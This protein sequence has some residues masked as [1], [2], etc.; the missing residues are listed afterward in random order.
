MT[1]RLVL[2]SKAMNTTENLF[3]CKGYANPDEPESSWYLR[4]ELILFDEKGSCFLSY[5][6][7][8]C[9]DYPWEIHLYMKI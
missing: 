5:K 2:F 3:Y 6:V 4:R 9:R 7:S 1:S 8:E